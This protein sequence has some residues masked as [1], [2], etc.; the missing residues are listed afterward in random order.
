MLESGIQTS[1]RKALESE[2]CYVVRV[3]KAGKSGTSDLIVC[4][5]VV[6]TDAMVGKEVGLFCSLEIKSKTGKTRPLQVYHH[7]KTAKAKGLAMVLRTAKEAREFLKGIS[8]W[9][10]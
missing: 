5:P 1:I 9:I 10:A 8:Q 3:T 7:R 6:I 4:A 2:G